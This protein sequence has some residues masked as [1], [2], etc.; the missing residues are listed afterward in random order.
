MQ[1]VLGDASSDQNRDLEQELD[2]DQRNRRGDRMVLTAVNKI[3]EACKEL[4]PESE[5]CNVSD[6]IVKLDKMIKEAVVKERARKALIKIKKNRNN[7]SQ[8]AFK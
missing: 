3:I 4:D 2:L 7:T 8:G 6:H 5:V 1:E